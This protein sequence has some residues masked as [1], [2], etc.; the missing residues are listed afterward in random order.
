MLLLLSYV[1]DFCALNTFILLAVVGRLL[2]PPPSRASP[3]S[4]MT[5]WPGYNPA[6]FYHFGQITIVSDADVS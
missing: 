3:L 4:T 2:P 5:S 6:G 1:A